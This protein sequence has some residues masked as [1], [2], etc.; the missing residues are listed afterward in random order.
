MQFRPDSVEDPSAAFPAGWLVEVD[1]PLLGL[2]KER[3]C[4]FAVGAADEVRALELV[5]TA[6]GGLHCAVHVKL[7]LS[8]RALAGMN[9]GREQVRML[10]GQTGPQTVA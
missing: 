2:N 9:V 7:K 3:R 6:V 5:R 10:P 8:Q 4:L 1:T